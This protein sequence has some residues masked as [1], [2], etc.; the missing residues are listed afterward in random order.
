MD[1]FDS[2]Q[3]YEGWLGDHIPLIKQDLDAKH[4]AMH[5]A[6]FPFL[7][8]T[9]YRWMQLWPETCP[10]LDAAPEVLSVGDL[11]VENLGTWRDAEGRLGWGIN[12]FD[13]AAVL[14]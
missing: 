8:A 14:P 4:Q 1:I 2:T 5:A 6:V 3:K 9:F 10:E 11:H 7:R 12:D 13:E